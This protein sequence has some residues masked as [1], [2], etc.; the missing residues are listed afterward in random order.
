MCIQVHELPP[1]KLKTREVIHID[2]ANDPISSA[3][4]KPTE[5]PTKYFIFISFFFLVHKLKN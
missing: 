1:E 5:D 4:Y 2:I 3:D